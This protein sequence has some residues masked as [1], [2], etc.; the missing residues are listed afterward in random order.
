MLLHIDIQFSQYHLLK[1]LSSLSVLSI[2]VEDQL[3]RYTW[4][5]FLALYPVP[6]VYIS[7]FL[8]VWYYLNY[9]GYIIY[10]FIFN[11][12]IIA[13]HYCVHFCYKKYVSA[14]SIDMSPCS[15]NS[16]PFS[17]PFHPSKL[18]QSTTVSSLC[19][20]QVPTSYLFYIW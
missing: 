7:I 19:F 10:Q 1:K 6:I 13:L 12:K 18:P 11:W 8:S 15:W 20:Q 4:V 9:C 14:I 2:L 17:T 5:Y 3:T 16:S